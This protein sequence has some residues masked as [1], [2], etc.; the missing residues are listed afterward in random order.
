MVDFITLDNY[1]MF[2]WDKASIV[3]GDIR[4]LEF[5]NEDCCWRCEQI[6]KTSKN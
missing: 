4:T 5:D 2:D 1:G 6:Y 3:E